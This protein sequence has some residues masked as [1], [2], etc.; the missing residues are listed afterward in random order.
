M[1]ST[2]PFVYNSEWAPVYFC[3][4]VD[5]AERK[6]RLKSIQDMNREYYATS[7]LP[8]ATCDTH[9]SNGMTLGQ[10]AIYQIIR[11]NQQRS[12]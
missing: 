7:Q 9:L 5:D 2:S 1:L 6:R 3:P 12:R 11:K 8:G 10:Y 4:P